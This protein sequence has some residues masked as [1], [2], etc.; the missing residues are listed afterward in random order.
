M[1][2]VVAWTNTGILTVQFVGNVQNTGRNFG[3]RANGVKIIV[4]F[5]VFL[6]RVFDGIGVATADVSLHIIG[7]P[8][9]CRRLDFFSRIGGGFRQQ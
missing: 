5:T 3:C 1:I 7:Q 6:K 9:N 4:V 2:F 8:I